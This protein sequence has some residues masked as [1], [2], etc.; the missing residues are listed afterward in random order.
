MRYIVT[1]QVVDTDVEA[2]TLKDIVQERV[3]SELHEQGWQGYVLTE[4]PQRVEEES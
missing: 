4:K 3:A 2:S 1:L